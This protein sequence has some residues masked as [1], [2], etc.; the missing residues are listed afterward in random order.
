MGAYQVA[1]QT[2]FK[3]QFDCV[4][5]V[6]FVSVRQPSFMGNLGIPFIFGPVAGGESA[7]WRLRFGYGLRGLVLDGLRD[8]LNF[9]I[10]TSQRLQTLQ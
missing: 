2:H 5:H 9:M 8:L 1:K 10:K 3:I 4:H 7:P 6:T